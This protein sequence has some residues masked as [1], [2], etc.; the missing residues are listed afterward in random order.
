M[1]YDLEWVTLYNT[2]E[3][4]AIHGESMITGEQSR[5][6]TG[7]EK[8]ELTTEPID[9]KLLLFVEQEGQRTCIT[10][11]EELLAAIKKHKGWT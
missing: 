6:V 11:S 3:V 4:T 2:V 8:I 7:I 5:T 10:M 9:K 1:S